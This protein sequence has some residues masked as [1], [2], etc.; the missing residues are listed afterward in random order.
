MSDARAW[1]VITGA[2]SGIGE[3]FAHRLA[4]GGYRLILTARRQSML[5]ELA[6]RLPTEVRVVPADLGLAADR[7]RLWQ[8]VQS[9]PGPIDLLVNNAGFG[10]RGEMSSIDRGRQLEMIELNVVALTDLAHRYLALRRASGGGA[11][12]NVAS[13]LGL[14]P[15]PEM[16]VYSATKCFV[17]ALSR[18]LAAEV[19]GRGTR[20]LA[21][22]PGPVPTE[23]QQVAGYSLDPSS[24]RAAITA[25][26]TVDE[27]LAA[28]RRG[29]EVWVPGR[30]VRNLMRVARLMPYRLT[31][32]LSARA[33][34]R[35]SQ[36]SAASE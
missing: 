10:A 21:L 5:E 26:Q 22:C 33:I 18:A 2:S 4:A 12:I 20:V 27:A 13:V 14:V 24:S 16:A 1:A 34:R 9:A 31:S 7:D 36:R 17:V 8:A 28:L 6:A 23:F 11:L 25:E 32:W 15:S 30:L 29:A 19:R 3:A 35:R